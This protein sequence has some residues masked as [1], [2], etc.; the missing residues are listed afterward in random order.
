MNKVS[1]KMVCYNN[2]IWVKKS[3]YTYICMY[4]HTDVYNRK[5]KTVK[6][7]NGNGGIGNR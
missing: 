1:C 4:M 5:D 6:S 2:S 3:I 7:G